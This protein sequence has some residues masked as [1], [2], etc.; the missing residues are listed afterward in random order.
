MVRAVF[1]DIDGTL[2]DEGTGVPPSAVKAIG[3]C[4]E[5]GV[6]VM[7]CTGRNLASI[8]PDVRRIEVDGII[9]GG[10]CLIQEG[11][12]IRKN[13][14]F[15]KKETVRMISVL[16]GM[17]LPFA[18]ES[19]EK[20]FM[21]RRAA[22]W[23]GRDFEEKLKGLG[24]EA[25]ARR[26]AENEICY[27]DNLGAYNQEEDKIHKLCLWCP[28]KLYSRLYAR[29]QDFGDVAQQTQV[30]R[31]GLAGW[32]YLEV[33][34]RGC[35]KG[36]AIREWCHAVRIDLRDTMSFGDGKNDIDMVRTTGVGVAMADG[37]E[38]LKRYA[39]AVCEPA[40]QDGIYRELIRQRVIE[41]GGVRNEY[42]QTGTVVE[43]RGS[44]P[45]LSPQL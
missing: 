40:A 17:D 3:M 6:L 30:R 14:F 11:R 45:D 28:P 44:I 16:S 8:Q 34:P 12:L 13:V 9:A 23:L 7:I 5:K 20:I 29:V 15:Q 43:G 10:G 25:R 21:N 18:L 27:S 22:D 35:S 26:R 37:D 42:K 4:R 32:Q 1:L 24:A 41:T 2:R 39:G 36:A 31:T 38:E 19:Q 33:L